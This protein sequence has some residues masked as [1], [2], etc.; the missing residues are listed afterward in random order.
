MGSGQRFGKA[1]ACLR[2][3]RQAAAAAALVTV[4]SGAPY[5][6]AEVTHFAVRLR[7]AATGTTTAAD[8]G[9]L[10]AISALARTGI[11]AVSVTHDGAYRIGLAPPLSDDGAK[12]ALARLR[13]DP[14]VLYAEIAA[15]PSAAAIAA[16]RGAR[17]SPPIARI[18]VKF[19]DPQVAADAAADLPLA[20]S[21]VA[22]VATRAGRP[23]SFERT[24]GWARAHVLQLLSRAPVDEAEAI[25]NAIAQDPDV[26]WAQP[27][28]LP[29]P[30]DRAQRPAVCEPV[31]LLLLGTAGG[32]PT[33]PTPGTA[34]RAGRACA[35]AVIDTGA[36]YGPPGPRRPVHRRL[37]LHQRLRSSPT[38]TTRCCRAA[39]PRNPLAAGCNNRDAECVGSGRLGHGRRSAARGWLQGSSA[40]DNSS[41]HGSHVAGT[42]GAATNN[43]TGVA[44]IN[45]VQPDRAVCA[46]SA[47]AAAT[48]PTSPMRWIG[49]PAVR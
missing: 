11:G 10:Q 49:P 7:D 4:F 17:P 42:V 22:Q 23:M 18:I 33:C 46:C 25:A 35:T 15:E 41:W 1:R 8:L 5:A 16:A 21:R 43:A 44:G 32:G 3:Q 39:A 2:R 45:W 27:D 24:I 9:R 36:L 34:R 30:P 26:E 14:G 20:A 48:T 28:Y 37:R 38:T 47:S 12:T 31:A 19:R 29:L 6:F 13:T 40:V